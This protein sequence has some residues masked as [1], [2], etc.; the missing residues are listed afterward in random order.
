M[1]MLVIPIIS[2]CGY[3]IKLQ[4]IWSITLDYRDGI[5]HKSNLKLLAYSKALKLNDES[6]GMYES[7]ILKMFSKFV[8]TLKHSC[9][10]VYIY[11]SYIQRYS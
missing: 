2:L 3:C 9:I 6:L 1:M 11:S 7:L 5:N 4:S 8:P 10:H